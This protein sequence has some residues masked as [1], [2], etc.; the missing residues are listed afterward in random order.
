MLRHQSSV[1]KGDRSGSCGCH[2]NVLWQRV[3][4]A[5]QD[6]CRICLFGSKLGWNLNHKLTLTDVEQRCAQRAY[7][8]L[9]V[10]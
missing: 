8:H 2:I 1:R 6:H 7:Q 5:N 9:H 3:L 10:L 4:V